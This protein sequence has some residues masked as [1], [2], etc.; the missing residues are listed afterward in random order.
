MVRWNRT[1]LSRDEARMFLIMGFIL[2]PVGLVILLVTNIAGI[3]MTTIGLFFL[4]VGGYYYIR[5]RRA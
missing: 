5:N 3:G 2:F 1:S 4:V